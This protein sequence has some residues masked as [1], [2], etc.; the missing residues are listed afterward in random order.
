MY[1]IITCMAR[2]CILATVHTIYITN[3]FVQFHFSSVLHNRSINL[4]Q[5]FSEISLDLCESPIIKIRLP[6]AERSQWFV[7]R[8]FLFYCK[9]IIYYNILYISSNSLSCSTGHILSDGY[10]YYK[11]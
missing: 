5:Q 8:R 3:T 1:F 6:R 10:Q 2:I 11:I 4:Q 9:C 7:C